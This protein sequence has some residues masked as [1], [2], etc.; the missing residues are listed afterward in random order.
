MAIALVSTLVPIG[1]LLIG[2]ILRSLSKLQADHA[3][4]TGKMEGLTARMDAM[5]ADI[6]QIKTSLNM[7]TEHLLKGEKL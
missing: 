2:W 7:I 5:S 3:S 6:A 1:A 4:L